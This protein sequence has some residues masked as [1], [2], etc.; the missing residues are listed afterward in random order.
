MALVSA[1]IRDS[2]IQL[3]SPASSSRGRALHQL[4]IA[5]TYI[6]TDPLLIP[7]SYSRPAGSPSDH[8]LR[9]T[10][11]NPCPP[12]L[13]ASRSSPDSVRASLALRSGRLPLLGERD[14]ERRP[15][16]PRCPAPRPPRPVDSRDAV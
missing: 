16:E 1:R 10:T 12:R 13:S 9:S 14:L 6:S 2:S 8:C 15:R 7:W 5:P 4:H 3:N 11:T